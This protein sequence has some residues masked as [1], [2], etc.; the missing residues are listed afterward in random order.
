MVPPTVYRLHSEGI[1]LNIWDVTIY[2]GT[3]KLHNN[4][5]RPLFKVKK[6]RLSSHQNVQP[7][8]LSDPPPIYGFTHHYKHKGCACKDFNCTSWRFHI[9]V[10]YILLLGQTPNQLKTSKWHRYTHW[11]WW[12][13]KTL[14]VT[15]DSA[16]VDS[17]RFQ[18]CKDAVDVEYVNA[19]MYLVLWPVCGSSLGQIYGTSGR[20]YKLRCLF[21]GF[22]RMISLKKCED[23]V[24][25]LSDR[26]SKWFVSSKQMLRRGSQS[27]SAS[28]S[29]SRRAPD[30][31][32]ITLS[33]RSPP[34]PSSS[35][36]PIWDPWFGRPPIYPAVWPPRKSQLLSPQAFRSINDDGGASG[37][38]NTLQWL[39]EYNNG[40]T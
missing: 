15:A 7:T 24:N 14:I 36:S 32:S 22:L 17:F 40:W 33:I 20:R 12:T 31:D 21:S 27:V 4:S 26:E 11:H 35:H 13:H 1:F 16:K 23:T 5:G 28:I 8:A 10:G 39:N 2:S 37:K 19:R 30:P 38:W 6:G 9:D 34:L 29:V 18:I 25:L 3:V